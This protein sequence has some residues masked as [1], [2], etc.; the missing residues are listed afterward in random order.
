LN[1]LRLLKHR[2][3]DR[4]IDWRLYFAKY[5]GRVAAARMI[6]DNRRAAKSRQ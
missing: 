5:R 1:L 4:G 2:L 6:C 3:L